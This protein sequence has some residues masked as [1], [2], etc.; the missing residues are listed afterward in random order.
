MST[1][2]KAVG[3]FSR[4]IVATSSSSWFATS[5]C[6]VMAST[7]IAVFFTVAAAL[8]NNAQVGQ[9]MVARGIG[10]SPIF[11]GL[12]D[13]V[14]YRFRPDRQGRHLQNVIN[15]AKSEP[16]PAR[17]TNHDGRVRHVGYECGAC[18]PES[19]L[20]VALTN[21]STL[22][23]NASFLGCWTLHGK[24]QPQSKVQKVYVQSSRS[25]LHS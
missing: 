11:P 19:Y 21:R 14:E 18:T 5:C 10:S 3:A 8:V 1:Q 4:E 6:H 20:E 17:K 15:R 23:Y 25:W 16:R 7:Q 9:Q 12:G 24:L 2:G 13:P 22:P